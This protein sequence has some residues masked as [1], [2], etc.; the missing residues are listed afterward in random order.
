MESKK[1]ELMEE[2]KGLGLEPHHATGEL[3][4]QEMINAELAKGES[5]GPALNAEPKA[6]VVEPPKVKIEVEVAKGKPTVGELRAA[7]RKKQSKLVRVIVHC[8]ND[9]K[10]EWQ[11]EIH[12]VICAAGTLKK[13]VPFGNEAGWHVP[14]AILDVMKSKTCQKFRSAKLPNGQEHNISYSVKEYNIE[15]MKPL[16]RGELKQ[17]AADQ[18]AR[19]SI[20]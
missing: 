2:A 11:G 20:G 5:D 9:K 13:W 1:A 3:K 8:N 18:S 19:G 17:L 16:T 10:K 14:Q 15:V 7:L 12:S 6:E 4:L